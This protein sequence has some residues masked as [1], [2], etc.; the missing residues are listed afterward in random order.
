MGYFHFLFKICILESAWILKN[1]YDWESFGFTYLHLPKQEYCEWQKKQERPKWKEEP[2]LGLLSWCFI[3]LVCCSQERT[4]ALSFVLLPDE[5]SLFNELRNAWNSEIEIEWD[6]LHSTQ[7]MTPTFILIPSHITRQDDLEIQSVL[8]M[9]RVR[10]WKMLKLLTALCHKF[11]GQKDVEHSRAKGK[12]SV[13][14]VWTM[15]MSTPPSR[16][17]YI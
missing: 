4:G 15:K 11:K 6:F 8:D 17:P 5:D 7:L 12:L 14:L 13:G 9:R 3:F 1:S 2:I 16:L 10:R